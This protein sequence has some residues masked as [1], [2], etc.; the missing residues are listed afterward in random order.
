MRRCPSARARA[1]ATAPRPPRAAAAATVPR[2]PP[3]PASAWDTAW[4]RPPTATS[5][6]TATH[7]PTWPS[8]TA[9]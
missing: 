5:T 8:A 9:R 3:T 1:A 4:R 2:P 6:P 7:A